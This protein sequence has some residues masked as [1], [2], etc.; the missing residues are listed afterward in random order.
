MHQPVAMALE[1]ARRLRSSAGYQ[2][3]SAAERSV[4]SR[5]LSRIEAALTGDPYARVMADSG[6]PGNGDAKPA[7]PPPAPPP[8]PAT[9][10]I[11][12]R[13]ADAL[14][15]VNFS[16][17]VAGLVTGAFQAIVDATAQQVKEYASLV[18]SIS[19][20][21]E[22]FSRD[23]V[24]PGQVRAWLAER[25]AS[26]LQVQLPAAGAAGSARLVPQPGSAGTSPSW[27]ANFGLQ[28][29]ELSDQLTEGPLLDAA[30]PRLG[31]ERLQTLATMVLMGI[32]R[33][34]VD[35]GDI[36]ARLQFHAVARDLTNAEMAMGQMAQGIAGRQV[37]GQSPVTTM[38]S[39]LKA[40]AQ[41]DA[42]IKTD[43][44]GEVRIKFRSETF[45]LERFADSQAIQLLNRHAR[46]TSEPAK[47]NTPP[48]TP[49]E[50]PEGGQ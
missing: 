38:V 14:A 20:S 4:F 8:P 13:A 23:N 22:S 36:T 37:S 6:A 43:L 41:A 49:V 29:E 39:T 46:W 40:N 25:Y 3:L 50:Q 44:M 35:D 26:D 10:Q 30:Q 45:P 47:K 34:V 31:E 21:V 12:G 18:A 16:G 48:P 1:A 24:S 27:L 5:D 19:Q 17:F 15:A 11:G 28:G 32:N 2:N 9:S 33:I 42:S 7:P